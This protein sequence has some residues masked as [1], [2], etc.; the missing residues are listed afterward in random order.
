[1][2][3]KL[4][5]HKAL[6]SGE[7][8]QRAIRFFRSQH[9]LGLSLNHFFGKI[10]RNLFSVVSMAVPSALLGVL[11]FIT[12]HLKGV[13]Y[14]SWLG[15]FIATKIGATHYITMILALIIAVVTATEIIWQNISD[16]KEEISLYKALG[17][18]NRNVMRVVLME[19]V[20][21]GV[22][23]GLFSVVL[24]MLSTWLLF[25]ELRTDFLIYLLA[26]GAIPVVM[27]IVAAVVPALYAVSVSPMG[28]LARRSA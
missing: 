1:M 24:S 17:W 22:F 28:G 23:A 4:E 20:L 11:L 27:G 19:G 7:V 18:K 3:G 2:A 10:K 21:T 15:Q 5:P 6:Q 26:V 14:T 8:T 25:Q 13:L 16:R 9:T 12:F